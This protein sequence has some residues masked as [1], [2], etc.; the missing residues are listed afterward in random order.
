MRPV[1]RPQTARKQDANRPIWTGPDGRRGG[2]SPP[3]GCPSYVLMPP[4]RQKSFS[5]FLK[6]PPVGFGLACPILVFTRGGARF[7]EFQLPLIFFQALS[8]MVRAS[9]V[10]ARKAAMVVRENGSFMGLSGRL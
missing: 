1:E 4:F 8:R 6:F 9:A 7:F 2:R 10:E 3:G 5:S